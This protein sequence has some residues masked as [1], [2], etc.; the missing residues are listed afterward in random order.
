M[1]VASRGTDSAFID[2]RITRQHRWFLAAGLAGIAASQLAEMIVRSS[3]GAA[4]GK[5]PPEDPLY[6]DVDWP[7]ALLFAAGTGALV[8]IAELAGRQA[9]AQAWRRATGRRPPQ[10]KRRTRR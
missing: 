7:T 8:A 4:A 3:W 5:E 9:A 6:E 1:G 10:P 2:M